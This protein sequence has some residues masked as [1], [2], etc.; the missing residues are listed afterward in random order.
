[1]TPRSW[2]CAGTVATIAAKTTA[3]R[4]S[5]LP[6]GVP[7]IVRSEECIGPPDDLGRVDPAG[8]LVPGV[9]AVGVSGLHVVAALRNPAGGTGYERLTLPAHR[10]GHAHRN[11]V[12]VEAL[13]VARD[14]VAWQAGEH[15]D[16]GDP[17]R[18]RS[19]A[20]P[21][22]GDEVAS[23]RHLALVDEE[24]PVRQTGRGVQPE[25]IVG[26]KPERD[27]GDRDVDD[28]PVLQV[29]DR[30]LGERAQPESSARCE[31]VAPASMQEQG[32]H[33]DSRC[34]YRP[35]RRRT[36]GVRSRSRGSEPVTAPRAST[37]QRHSAGSAWSSVLTS[38]PKPAARR[39]AP[40]RSSS[41]ASRLTSTAATCSS[42]RR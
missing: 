9:E 16:E 12:E 24:E 39:S 34:S 26:V 18:V 6:R 40:A 37:M 23:A 22:E 20:G 8:Q 15:L 28:G 36:S 19:A 32:A 33:A 7:A 31:T 5:G 14:L 41:L 10:F 38:V 30:A 2:A 35:S 27:R 17:R 25:A 21:A 4:R 3:A 29:F 13:R 42:F 1:M 11:A